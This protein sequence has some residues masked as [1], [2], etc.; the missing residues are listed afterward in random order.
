MSDEYKAYLLVY[1]DALERTEVRKIIK[2]MNTVSKWRYDLPNSFYLI[3][4]SSAQEISDEF[5]DAFGG[6]NYRFLVTEI[7]K[8]KQGWL[9]KE[10]WHLIN[11]KK[12]RDKE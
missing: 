2:S 1:T 3:S 7:G 4:Y 12:F 10:T 9:P 5:R 11:K 8:N 6:K